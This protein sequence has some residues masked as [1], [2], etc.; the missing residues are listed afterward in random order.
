[1][2]SSGSG[3]AHAYAEDFMSLSPKSHFFL[4][5]DPSQQIRNC[6]F[7]VVPPVRGFAESRASK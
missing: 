3:A 2:D 4:G 7:H 1:M 6:S 5:P